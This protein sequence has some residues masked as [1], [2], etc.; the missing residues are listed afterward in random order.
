MLYKNRKERIMNWTDIV[1]EVKAKD[2]DKAEAI[3][4]M[5]V[6]RGLYIE[7]YSTFEEDLALTGPI[8]IVDEELYK[9]DKYTIKIHVYVSPEE[10]PSETLS[11]L[12]DRLK[13]ERIDYE[14]NVDN[15]SEEDWANNWKKYFKPTPVGENLIIVPTWEQKN[16]NTDRV[17][18]LIDPGMAFGSGQHETTRLCLEQI[19]KHLTNGAKVLDVGTGSGI[20]AIAA[21]LLGAGKVTGVDIDPLSIKTAK[22]NA[23]LNN[24]NE[25][26]KLKT[27]NLAYDVTETFDMVVA[28]IVAD[29]IIELL[30]DAFIKLKPEGIFIASGIIE[31]REHDVLDALSVNGF[32]PIEVK[33]DKGW[34]SVTAKRK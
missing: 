32:A 13:S 5:A 3:A 29:V 22:E 23:I 27:G 2:K 4:H 10:N 33:H 25:N 11:F 21:L 34:V 18:L 28:N 19:E 24:V 7:D 30:P 8:E 31:A 12:T 1:V 9:K 6:P 16:L 26:L 15:I 20:L 14:L 17:V